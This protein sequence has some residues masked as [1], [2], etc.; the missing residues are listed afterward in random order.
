MSH[1]TFHPTH[2]HCLT[3]VFPSD[4]LSRHVNDVAISLHLINYLC[5]D[6][7]IRT[8]KSND[9]NNER[10][11]LKLQKRKI[12]THFTQHK[13]GKKMRQ[14]LIYSKKIGSNDRHSLCHVPSVVVS[15]HNSLYHPAFSRF[16]KCV[17]FLPITSF[18]FQN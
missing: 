3:M 5:L 8:W 13:I 10:L 16:Q 9:E 12:K 1:F 14:R 7:F 6:D 18:T 15:L 2:M 4:S 11:G 17:Y